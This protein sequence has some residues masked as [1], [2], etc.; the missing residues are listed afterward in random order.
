M[1]FIGF[2]KK[3]DLIELNICEELNNSITLIEWPEIF[4]KTMNE[5][6]FHTI[7]FEFIN[8]YRRKIKHNL[9]V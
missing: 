5:N 2:Q 6:K 3:N 9:L 1:I 4:L 8:E 7:K